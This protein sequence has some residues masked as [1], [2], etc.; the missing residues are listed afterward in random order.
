MSRTGQWVL[1]M[2]EDAQVMTFMEF[3]ARH[4]YSAAD[5]WHEVRFGDDSRDVEPDVEA[6]YA[7]MDDGA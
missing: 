7:E 1:E 2:Q 3:V 5:V 4:G 6:Y